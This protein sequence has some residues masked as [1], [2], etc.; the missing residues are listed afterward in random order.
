M[1]LLS[2]IIRYLQWPTRDQFCV[3]SKH[4]CAGPVATRPQ[5]AT[6]ATAAPAA[7]W[8]PKL[9]TA[10]HAEPARSLAGP[11]ASRQTQ[12]GLG[13]GTS[14]SF[15][16]KKATTATTAA[17]AAVA[18]VSGV[19]IIRGGGSD[20]TRAANAAANAAGNTGGSGFTRTANAV[21]TAAAGAAAVRGAVGGGITG[22]RGSLDAV[23]SGAGRR[24]KR[25]SIRRSL[26][27]T[28]TMD[29]PI[30]ED[31]EIT[32]CAALCSFLADLSVSVCWVCRASSVRSLMMDFPIF[33]DTDITTCAAL[34]LSTQALTRKYKL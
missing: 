2:S 30:Y 11:F 27:A 21:A 14:S 24:S 6:D 5:D 28:L 33:E 16:N 1:E 19:G 15:P 10:A 23:R 29:F 26:G 7:R 25:K 8:V 22:R 31:T 3:Q 20:F 4:W 17:A 9:A 12:R 18:G 34:Y 13:G 32:T